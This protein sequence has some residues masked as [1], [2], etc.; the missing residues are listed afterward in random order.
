MNP[1]GFIQINIY[2]CNLL[3][4]LS[5][6]TTLSIVALRTLALQGFSSGTQLAF[7]VES[8]TQEQQSIIVKC[9]EE[10]ILSAVDEPS[11]PFS[12][13]SLME[14]VRTYLIVFPL[15]G[16]Y[17]SRCLLLAPHLDFLSS[18]RVACDKRRS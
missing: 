1:C 2:V 13:N 18:L 3:N 6:E 14:R 12:M 9:C 4:C 11:Q 17:A 16:A 8:G 5:F 7:G 15:V 10:G